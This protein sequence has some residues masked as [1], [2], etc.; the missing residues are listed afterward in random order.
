MARTIL[1]SSLFL[2][3]FLLPAQDVR[4]VVSSSAGDR[5]TEK[6]ALRFKPGAPAAPSITIDETKRFQTM[7]GFGATFNEAGL[8]SLNKLPASEQERVLKS[9]F[10]EK[11]GA[12]YTLMKSPLAACDF[13]AAG[14]MY[15]YTET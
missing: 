14:S 5:I 12:G 15:F 7:E 9:L 3:A 4:L 1:F 11:E 6:P 2:A 8:I 10:D 13:S